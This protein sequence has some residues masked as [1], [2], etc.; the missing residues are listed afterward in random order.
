MTG[1][2]ILNNAVL[3]SQYQ[4]ISRNTGNAF[5]VQITNPYVYHQ[6]NMAKNKIINLEDPT[7]D[8]DAISKQYLEK[9]HVKPSYYNNE[10]KND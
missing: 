5:F 2:I 4:A 3:T 7:D 8:T 1:H 10:F 6:F 9:S